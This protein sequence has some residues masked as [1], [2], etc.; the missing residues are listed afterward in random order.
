MTSYY[1]LSISLFLFLLV[2]HESSATLFDNTEMC[3]GNILCLKNTNCAVCNLCNS[4]TCPIANCYCPS[5]KIPGN[6]PLSQ[7]PQF[8]ILTFDDTVHETTPYSL[9]TKLDYWL[10]DPLIVDKAGCSIRPTMFTMNHF[11]D[12]AYISYLDKIGEVSIHS[13]T[14]TTSFATTYRKWKN[15]LTTDYNDIKELAQVTS[16]GS[17][18]PYLEYNDDYFKVLNELGV[19]YDFSSVY[20]AVSYNLNSVKDQV[21]WWP[22]TLDF[23]FPEVSIGTTAGVLN[24]RVPGMW[25]FPMTGFQHA[26]KSEYDIMDMTIGDP[27][28]LF[29]DFKRDFNLNYNSNRAPFGLYF[30]ASYFMNVDKTADNPDVLELYAKILRYVASLNNVIFTTPQKIINWMKNPKPFSQTILLDDFKCPAKSITSANPCNANVPKTICKITGIPWNT[31]QDECPDGTF[32]FTICGNQCPNL[33]PDI[34]V[35][36]AYVGPKTRVYPAPTAFFDLITPEVNA[37]YYHFPGTATINDPVVNG[38]ESSSTGL[39]GVNGNFCTE[40]VIT[41][42]SNDEGATGFILTVEGCAI[43]SNLTSY[44]GYPV[45]K[46]TSGSGSSA[47]A[48]FRMIGKNVQFMRITDTT[49]GMICM[50]VN[51]GVKNTF[52]I[53]SLKTGVDLYNQTLRCDFGSPTFPCT[54]FCGNKVKNTGENSQNCPIDTTSRSCPTSRL[55]FLEKLGRNY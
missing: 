25:E 55:L 5:K 37:K 43:N 14:H 46:Y 39:F 29:N 47:V 49:I 1:Q 24:Q 15:E 38:T 11:S 22:F 41:N 8:F 42:P 54:I 6:I 20:Y 34:D 3:F 12:F 28:T 31:C 17:R 27:T 13:T 23:G 4:T 48:G 45:Q 19:S 7:T 35:N 33:M 50:S 26:D 36:W 10:N 40:I 52:K 32:S 51:K 2:L 18:A 16:K 9:K 44:Y 21:N 53:S 30:H